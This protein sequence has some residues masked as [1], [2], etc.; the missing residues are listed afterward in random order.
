MIELLVAVFILLP[1]FT[2]GMQVFIRCME[3]S[4]LAKNSSLAVWGAKNR[5]SAIEN[6]AYNQIFATYNNTT[7]SITGLTGMGITTVDNSNANHLT[8]TISFSWKERGGR[9][10]GE[11]T[12]LNGVLNAGED[13]NGNGQLDSIVKMTTQIYNM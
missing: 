2:I 6:T 3:L 5:F 13:I 1:L 11:D 7:F 8:V 12:N 9:I 10:I 4:D